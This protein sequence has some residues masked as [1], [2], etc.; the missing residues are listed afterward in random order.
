LNDIDDRALMMHL[1]A[2]P[3]LAE[4]LQD[5]C[6]YESKI[7][8]QVCGRQEPDLVIPDSRHLFAALPSF[9][10][11]A[12]GGGAG[13]CPAAPITSAGRF[14][15]RGFLSALHPSLL[16]AKHIGD[17]GFCGSRQCAAYRNAECALGFA[18]WLYSR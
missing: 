14:S 10:S 18:A 12:A 3:E 5:Q 13:A 11:W 16:G 7:A 17:K 4:S 6:E 2:V 15:P 1:G 9:Q 8:A